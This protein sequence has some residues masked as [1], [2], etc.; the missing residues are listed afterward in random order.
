SYFPEPNLSEE[1]S[2]NGATLIYKAASGEIE[3]DAATATPWI[4]V[5]SPSGLLVNA[6]DGR[7]IAARLHYDFDLA[8]GESSL[9]QVAQKGISKQALLDDLSVVVSN[10]LA[11]PQYSGVSLSYIP[12]G[13]INE[14]EVVDVMD[15]DDFAADLRTGQPLP[16]SAD[17]NGDGNVTFDDRVFLVRN[18]LNTFLGDAN[19]DGEFNS[20]DLSLVFQASEYFDEK[21]GNSVWATGDWNG[22]G[23]FTSGDLVAAF[24]ENSYEA[25]PRPPLTVP[26]PV[27][28]A[29]FV[30]FALL[31]T[32]YRRKPGR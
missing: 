25:G 23:E 16:A 29:P 21:V 32:G 9:G 8:A 14:D 20:S 27:A 31:L 6:D 4:G 18:V 28:F 11:Q 2:E 26:E 3:I 22:D 15:I 7:D 30:A 19:L 13:D 1:T 10:E 17:L 12:V 5:Y 24:K